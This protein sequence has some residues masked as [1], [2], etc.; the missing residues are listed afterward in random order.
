MARIVGQHLG[1]AIG[2]QVIVDNR[3]GAVAMS[4][5]NRREGRADG[6]TC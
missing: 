3:P 1:E 6:Y 4:A 5:P 2:Q